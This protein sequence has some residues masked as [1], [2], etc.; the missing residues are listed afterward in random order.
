MT[1][2]PAPTPGPRESRNSQGGIRRLRVG[3]V[4]AIV[5]AVGLVAWLIFRDDDSSDNTPQG[6]VSSAA[7]EDQL[8]A[9][10]QETGQPVYWAGR[11][12]GYT[13]ELTRT[14]DGNVFI[15]YLP[16]GV[17][18]GAQQ[19][20]YL[21]VGTYPRRRAL[22]QLRRLARRQGSVDFE[23]PNGGLA[24]YSRDRPNSVYVAF[25]GEDVQIEVYDPRAQRARSIVREGRVRPIG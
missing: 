9:L 6:P 17:Q 2:A 22:A 21:T 1:Q 19:P 5:L 14:N 16:A 8:R 23:A 7:S 3:A 20:D 12:G 4:I 11:R 18:P 24:V 15:R 10:P 13:Y 25:P